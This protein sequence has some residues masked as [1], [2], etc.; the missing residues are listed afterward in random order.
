MVQVQ[1]RRRLFLLGI[2]VAILAALIYGFRPQPVL[3]D[4]AQ[5]SRSGLEVT[6]EQE[7]KTRITDRYLITAPVAGH[8]QRLTLNVGETV[9]TGQAV[10]VLEPN[11]AEALDPRQ[12]AQ[13]QARVA[14]AEAAWAGAQERISAAQA[15]SDLAE[16]ELKR[17]RTLRAT[18]HASAAEEDRA[19]AEARRS[20]AELR[21]ARYTAEVARHEL[22]VART[23]L[24]HSAAQAGT[25]A[26]RVSV[27]IPVAGRV[28]KV[29]HKSEGAVTAGTPLLEIGD[30]RALEVEVDVLSADAVRIRP[31]TA[32]HFERWGGEQPLEGVVRVIEPVGFTKVSALGVEEQ[33]VWVI[34]DFTSPPA[35]W[36]RLGDGYRV[37][38][39][40]V[41]WAGQNVL[42]IP[43]SALFRAGEGW[44]VFTM[45][46]GRAQQRTVKVGQRNGLQAQIVSGL[47]EADFV[48]IHPDDKI[49]AGARVEPH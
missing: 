17:A 42:Q 20:T 27:R 23:A 6:V 19:S 32:V 3:V 29:H 45:E 7:G 38:A 21:A 4:T 25:G 8:A 47:S 44:A 1:W 5:V 16:A 18:Q 9:H 40:F 11:R 2:A 26:E 28:L 43:A 48:I 49:S 14:A 46:E 13:A 37:E 22:G 12:R 36:E 15:A 10:V 30:A 31:G 33:R 35:Q 39:R 34:C 41:L 24:Q